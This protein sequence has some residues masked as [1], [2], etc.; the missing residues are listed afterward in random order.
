MRQLKT[1]RMILVIVAIVCIVCINS[2]YAK[3]SVY[4]ITEH[5][6][7]TLKAYEIQGDQ[8]EFQANVA[9]TDYAGGAVDVTIDSD[10]GLFF[11][12]YEGETMIVWADARTLEQQGYIELQDIYP[13]ACPL[14]GIVADGTKNLVYTVE[15]EKNKLYILAWDAQ[16]EKEFLL[17]KW[18][19]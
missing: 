19:L 2:A 14:A 6:A 1:V 15:R 5:V 3:K 8:I 16:Q 11:I 18:R 17:A 10:L 13:S 12:T 4:A 9:V 7:S